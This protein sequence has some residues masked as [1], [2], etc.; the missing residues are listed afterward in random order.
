MKASPIQLTD[1]FVTDLRL[2]ANP[3]FDAKQEVPISFDNFEITIE[4]SHAPKSK[5]DWQIC[6][7][8]NHQPPA[9]ANVPYRFTA[10]IVGFLFVHPEFPEDRIE[11]LVKTN[12]ASMLFGA[13]REI[14]RDSTA[15]GPHSALF[16]PS[17]SFYEP[18]TKASS[19]S[20]KAP[21]AVQT[22]PAKTATS[23]HPSRKT[24]GN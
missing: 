12:G 3:K 24:T 13:L 10:E 18:E 6:L 15:R 4:T 2:S 20:S 8:L 22:S 7:K 9:E 19:V 17:T 5:R 21:P 11:R 23:K 14:I 16:L 1:Y